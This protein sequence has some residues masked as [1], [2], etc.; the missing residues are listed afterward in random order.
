MDEMGMGMLK[1]ISCQFDNFAGGGAGLEL[2]LTVLY[3]TVHSMLLTAGT[4]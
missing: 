2:E 4:T 3:D 1:W